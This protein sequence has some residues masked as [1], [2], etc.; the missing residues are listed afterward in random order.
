MNPPKIYIIHEND[1]WT[2]PLFKALEKQGVL[3]ESWF[4]N[5]G[6]VNLNALPPDG[7]FYNRMSASSHTRDHRYAVELTETLLSWLEQH[8]RTVVNDRRALT[9]EVRKTEQITALNTFGIPTP[10]SIVVN[11]PS[12]LIEAAK[13]LNQWP[14]I[15]KPNRGG[16][17][18]GVRLYHSLSQLEEDVLHEKWPESI[19]GILIVQEYIKPVDG[20]ITRVEMIG[21]E[22]YYAVS[23]DASGGFE[24]CPADVCNLD[25]GAFCPADSND[26]IVGE[27]PKF[28]II[29]D[30][31]NED[32]DRYKSLFLSRGI[33]IGALEYVMGTDGRRYVYDINTNTNYNSQAES[34]YEKE[35]SGME[36]IASYLIGKW[37]QVYCV[38]Q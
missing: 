18:L 1:E 36:E 27:R 29:K 24:L 15:V 3:Y 26:Q 23:V 19:D 37:E 35:V 10:T 33:S 25:E 4:V 13:E 12:N 14:F 7:I 28:Q 17:G 20:H 11:H 30:Y 22:P 2:Q 6:K 31:T 16:K 5:E 8:G 21:G 9:L 34:A 32:F 38:D